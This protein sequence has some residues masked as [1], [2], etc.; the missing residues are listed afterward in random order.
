M[1][2]WANPSKRAVTFNN[3]SVRV[4]GAEFAVLRSLAATPG[5]PVSKET[6]TRAALGREYVPY[7]RSIDVHIANL[8][9]KLGDGNDL[10]KTIRGAGYL[11]LD[12]SD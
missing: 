4:T 10:I 6:L 11:L 9:K 7:D 2:P 3:D 12:S 8:R 5:T 1:S